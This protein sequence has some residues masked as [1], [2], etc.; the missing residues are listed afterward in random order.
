M[1]VEVNMWKLEWFSD[2]FQRR[3]SRV[4]EGTSEDVDRECQEIRT[5]N[6]ITVTPIP[7]PWP[8][9]RAK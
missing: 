8:H 4:V 3:I 1:A 5:A 2:V 9:V 6:P 7:S